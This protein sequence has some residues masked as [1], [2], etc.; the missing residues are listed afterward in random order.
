MPRPAEPGRR[1]IAGLDGLRAVAVLSVIAY[2]LGFS[3]AGGGLLGVGVFFTLSGYL[4]TDL[5]M[6]DWRRHGHLRLRTFWLHRARRLLPALFSMLAVVS[7][8]VALLNPDWLGTVRQQVVSGSLYFAN[9]STI[10]QHGSYF[11]QFAPPMPLDHLWSL[12]IEEQF[13]LV[14]PLLL[15]VGMRLT[16]G[17]RRLAA[18][19]LVLTA[20][21]V[22]AMALLYHPGA[23]PTRV[24]E[25]T[26]TRA[27]A[28]LVGA[29]L[30]VFWPSRALH[31]MSRSRPRNLLDVTGLVG[32]A[33][34]LVL[35]WRTNALSSFLYPAG[36]LLLSLA[37]VAVVA[38]VVIPG[39]RL[40]NALGWRPVRWIGVRSYGI[41][42]WH[43]PIIVLIGKGS[44]DM[45]YVQAVLAVA[46]TLLVSDLSWRFLEQ[47]IRR[48][49]LSRLW[50][51]VLHGAGALRARRQAL[52][53]SGTAV[54]VSLPVLG[55]TGTLP[56]ALARVSSA[57]WSNARQVMAYERTE[58][59]RLA[60][61]W[62]QRTDSS[63]LRTACRSVVYIGDSTSTAEMSPTAI[64]D[65]AFRLD[66]QLADAGVETVHIE[67]SGGRSIVEV[68][69][70]HANAAT[71]AR[72]YM[73][74]GYRGC[75][76]IAIGTN[77]VRNT[78]A[79][80][81]PGL[82]TR[83]GQMMSIV[84]GQPVLWVNLKTLMPDSNLYG[85]SRMQAFDRDLR[86]AC[87]RHSN[88]RVFDWA[89][90]AQRKWFI[91]DGI[92]YYP[93]GYFARAYLIPRA[94]AVAFP[95]HGHSSA[96][97]LVG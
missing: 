46:L 17:R 75:W 51:H 3:W 86:A 21:S 68:W 41:Y 12:S 56:K 74:Q 50:G 73:A 62:V 19:P 7:V 84:H 9:W 2:H 47:P 61:Q 8:L 66:R 72:Q 60:S 1:Y 81:T 77:D 79:G 83:I 71:V 43:W 27:F 70:S 82:A 16:H 31:R 76:I 95:R 37:T 34:I 18:L 4:I 6:G 33:G 23:D 96:S 92:H 28:L 97:C 80:A 44:G 42:L 90:Y 54:M 35:E 11:A 40:G 91:Y 22:A 67:L 29:A 63:E 5:L 53:V 58:V 52:A 32:L 15:L 64:P 55:L 93:P 94:L 10:A 13:Y 78:A 87:R 26:D 24:Y 89:A 69:Q 25:G 30:A 36:F 20:A 65:P 49:S 14:W 48:G 59:G 57:P 39:S 85:A 38:A 88:L 45:R